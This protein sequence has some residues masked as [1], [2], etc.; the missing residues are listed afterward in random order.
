[1]GQFPGEG[2]D[3]GMGCRSLLSGGLEMPSE[4]QAKIER[5]ARAIAFLRGLKHG[6]LTYPKPDHATGDY[7]E[8]Y[9][10]GRSLAK[11][12]LAGWLKKQNLLEV[13]DDEVINL[14][15]RA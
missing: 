5:D 10:A 7:E 14:L 12:H 9:V 13:P 3:S 6:V 15:S 8:G 11:Q 4:M 1:M 2:G